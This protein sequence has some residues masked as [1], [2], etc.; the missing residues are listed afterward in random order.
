MPATPRAGGDARCGL[1]PPRPGGQLSRTV[2]PL[3]HA[4]TTRRRGATAVNFDGPRQRRGAPF[5][6]RQRADVAARLPR[7]RPAARRRPRDHRYARPSTS[8]SSS[9]ARS[10]R[11]PRELGR[12]LVLIAESD[13]QRSAAASRRA[14][15]GGYG[16]DAQWSDDFHHALHAVL[17][18]ERAGYYADFGTL[19]RPRQ[20]A[21]P[22]YVYDGRYSRYRRRRHG[23]PAAGLAGTA[24]SAI[25]RTTT[26]SATAPQ[27]ERSGAL[28]SARAG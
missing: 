23:R 28:M 18:G 12:H 4:T 24:S 7:R 25:C 27:G 16:L 8:S 6:L 17:T 19:A 5:L 15:R 11:S 21:A 14:R 26:R 20:G 1:Q 9:R 22:A 10:R 2:R 13:L 3:L